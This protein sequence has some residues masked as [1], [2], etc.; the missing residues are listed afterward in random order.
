MSQTT[1]QVPERKL[2]LG[3]LERIQRLLQ[4]GAALVLLVFLVLIGLALFELRG[5]Y[6]QIDERKA[7]LKRVND[8]VTQKE[9]SLK[10]LQSANGVLSKVADAYTEEHPEKADE[11]KDAVRDA[12]ET[13]IAQSAVQGGQPSEA[14]AKVPPRVYIQIMRAGQRRRAAEVARQLQA[15]GFLVP[16]IEN[17]ERKGR[18]SQP[19]S[20]VRFYDGDEM[21][22]ADTKEIRSVLDGFGLRLSDK[23]L[24]G[25]VRPRQYELWLG[26]DFAAPAGG[27]TPDADT[28]PVLPRRGEPN[29]NA[30]PPAVRQT[31]ERDR[32]YPRRP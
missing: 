30:S 1:P 15:K 22:D 31:P 14:T 21:A 29:T 4:Y 24:H 6:G 12:V 16:G 2:N 32:N 11:V 18:D 9:Q 5:L 23:K 25:S 13:S 10:A 8:E 19:N 26:D 3:R 20:D 28:S 7:E 27:D 17:M